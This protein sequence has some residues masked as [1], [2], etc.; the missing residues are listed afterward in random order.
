MTT[1]DKY[2]EELKKELVDPESYEFYGTFYFR[3]KENKHFGE[4]LIDKN[5]DFVGEVTDVDWTQ[6]HKAIKGKLSIEDKLMRMDFMKTAPGLFSPVYYSLVKQN[7][8]GVV[9]TYK[10]TWAF[11][12]EGI[13][14]KEIGEVLMV[15]R[16]EQSNIGSL[17]L[18][19]K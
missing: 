2:I 14:L 13:I 12:E 10:G 5:M 18:Y 6:V 8:N 15:E 1:V 7:N 17:T 3:G 19:K 11:K 4:L 9:G 16:P